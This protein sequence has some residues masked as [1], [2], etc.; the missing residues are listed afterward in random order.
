MYPT[1][2]CS[3][4][5]ESADVSFAHAPIP[6]AAWGREESNPRPTDT[7]SATVPGGA[8]KGADATTATPSRDAMWGD[9]L[10]GARP[11]GGRGNRGNRR[12]GTS[13]SARAVRAADGRS[14]LGAPALS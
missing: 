4:G 11:W 7:E 13:R 14:F 8:R 3:N 10:S 1:L 2:L 9:M 5:P 6:M 12:A